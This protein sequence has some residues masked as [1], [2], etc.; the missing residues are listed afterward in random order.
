VKVLAVETATSLQSVA[1]LDGAAA[2]VCEDREVR[3]AHAKHLVPTVDRVLMSAGMTLASLD[4]LIVSIGPGSFTGLRVGLATMMGFRMATGLPLVAVPTLEALAWHLRGADR[5]IC[6]MITARTGQVYWALYRWT[7]D[8]RLAALSE[9]RVGTVEEA[10]D[11]LVEPVIM[12]GEGWPR[13]R[14]EIRR[15]LGDRRSL[16]VDGPVAAN[17]A[18]AVMVGRAGLQRLERG[19]VAG[20][21]LS[22]RYV[23]RAEAELKH[24]GRRTVETSQP[25]RGRHE[26]GAGSAGREP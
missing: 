19:E 9:E 3:M 12:C 23:Q 15:R 1:I 14:D 17:R 22:P 2:I 24:R 20:L 6:P 10:V 5:P 21:G 7:V 18:S 25:V 8:H 4:A 13:C 16:A 26:V 11:S